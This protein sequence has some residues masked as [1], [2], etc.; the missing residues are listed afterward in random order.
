MQKRTIVLIILDGWGIG[1]LDESNPIH[2]IEPENIAFI[3][4]NYPAGALQASGISVGLPGGEEGNSEVGHLNIGAGKTIYQHFPRI[5]LAIRNESFFQNEPLKKAF[6][7]AKKNASTVHFVGLLGSGN[8]HSSLEHLEALIKFA[9]KEGAENYILHL[10]TDGRDSPPE[11]AIQ[12]L[13]KIPRDRL[14]SLSGR[15]YAMDRDN[16]FERT[17][18]VY[19]VL[20]GD[21]PVIQDIEAHIKEAYAE[22][23]N[24]EYVLP[25]LIGPEKRFIK[26]ND[27]VIF[28]DFREDRMRQIASPFV[29]AGFNKFNTKP[30][31]NVYCVTMT[32]YDATFNV[33]VAFMP[34][35]AK[36]PLGKVL[37]DRGLNQLRIAE[38]QKYPHITYFFNGLR[39]EPFK[40]E[41]RVLIPS[42]S[43]LRQDDHP[44]MMAPEITN[45][46]IES[47]EEGAYDF[48]LANYA[49]PD[50]MAHT[51]NYQ[52]C[53]DA[54]QI[55]DKMM[56]RVVES[57]LKTNAV[58]IITSD[59]GNMERVFDPMTGKPETQH[60]P[61]PV[62]IYLVASE[63]RLKEK[64]TPQA[65]KESE[66]IIV[67]ILADVAPTILDLI[68]TPRP[69]EMTGQSL[70]KLL[71]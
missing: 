51:G 17:E 57:C 52:A 70:V 43:L 65:I 62:P 35:I 1:N 4:A 63:F 2:V 11:S 58:L 26:N 39:E 64:K 38:T 67:G 16:H 30:L 5:T 25:A 46:L 23:L 45:R 60:D 66:K 28:F 29:F 32:Q 61:N 27:A 56:G 53:L 69:E 13:K 15:F 18:R 33:P 54:I 59:H 36:N 48:I 40:N 71:R 24:D 49:N 19:Q 34:D 21:G 50:M 41:Y 20:V 12:L 7:H 8:V 44:E 31:D 55:T 37:S 14:A 47:I 9:G 10:F 3:K 6:D 22:H 68:G 42:K